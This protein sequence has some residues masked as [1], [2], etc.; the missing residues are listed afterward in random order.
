MNFEWC[1]YLDLAECMTSSPATENVEACYRTA[2]SRAYYAAFCT[3]REYLNQKTSASYNGGDAHRKVREDLR[4]CGKSRIANQ[5][6][7]IMDSRHKADYYNT[8][9]NPKSE[10]LK[11][12]SKAKEIIH[13]LKP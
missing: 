8:F 6:E 7:T 11:T 9:N 1:S 5:L 10:A 13:A 12:I 2:I 4:R 3:A